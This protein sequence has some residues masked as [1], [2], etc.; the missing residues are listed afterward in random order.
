MIF[1]VSVLKCVGRLGGL[2]SCGLFCAFGLEA[3]SA[4]CKPDEADVC[5]LLKEERV[6]L[7]TCRC[8]CVL[9][10]TYVRITSCVISEISFS[11]EYCV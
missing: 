6:P 8:V 7:N 9:K 2:L 5:G 3:V 10:V 1:A 4:W 11:S